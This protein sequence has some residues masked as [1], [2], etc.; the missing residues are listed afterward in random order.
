MGTKRSSFVCQAC[1]ASQARWYGRCPSCGEWNSLVETLEEDT[2]TRSIRT[3]S[4]SS[5]KLSSLSI[6]HLT[7][8]STTLSEFDRVLG[9]GIVAGAV[10]LLAGEP[11]IGKSTL[12]LQLASKTSALYV[13]GEESL[14]Q[15]HLR[16]TRLRLEKSAITLL[17]ETDVDAITQAIENEKPPFVII[18]SIQ[19]M[20]TE[21]LTGIP[22]SVGQVR[23]SAHR[24]VRVA[25]SLHIPVFL[26]GHV[27]KEGSIAGPKVLEHMVDTVLSLEGERYHAFRVLRSLKNRFGPTDE[28]GVFEMREDGMKEV[29]N[30]SELFLSQRQDKAPGSVVVPVLEGTRPLLVEV[31]ALVAPTPYGFPKRA[32]SG[33]DLR[34]LELLVA[35]LSKTKSTKAQFAKLQSSDV[36]VNVA[37]GLRLREPAIDLGIVL[38][39]VS[40]LNDCPLSSK[41]VAIG[42]VGLL[43]EIRDVSH[44]EKRV[45]E[46][47]R[48]GY[49]RAVTPKTAETIRDAIHLAFKM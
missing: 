42:E 29:T 24:F 43:G 1:G 6:K 35:V 15:I 19:T 26:V 30:P 37:G 47:K 3:R 25:K 46:A 12:L 23:E 8:Q 17:S 32:V 39:I 31:Q 44:L 9:G 34:R 2:K 33:V 28:V 4:V 27:T 40:S 20:E 38:A 13:S 5:S 45:K 18:D 41:T 21:D 14:S 49:L 48:L 10:M 36:Y 22:G 16:A 7:R 11:G